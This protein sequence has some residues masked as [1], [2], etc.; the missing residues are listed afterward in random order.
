MKSIL[1][2]LLLL[3]S[4][5]L[6]AQD[7]IGF[8]IVANISPNGNGSGGAATG[9]L[10]SPW[11]NSDRAKNAEARR[12][13]SEKRYDDNM[14]VIVNKA[15]EYQNNAKKISDA[16]AEP[17]R[18]KEIL[19][20]PRLKKCYDACINAVN[21]LNQYADKV[22][23]LAVPGER[24]KEIYDQT[25]VELQHCDASYSK[26]GSL[27]YIANN[28]EQ[29]YDSKNTLFE[30][31]KVE[32]ANRDKIY[33]QNLAIQEKLL[34][35]ALLNQASTLP[36][37]VIGAGGII[38]KTIADYAADVYLTD[39]PAAKPIYV[40]TQK[41]WESFVDKHIIE[42]EPITADML[43]KINNQAMFRAGMA[44]N[45][46]T[47]EFE[48]HYSSAESAEKMI[49]FFSNQ[50]IVIK[51]QNQVVE[52]LRNSI[53][54]TKKLKRLN[55]ERGETTINGIN[56]YL[57]STDTPPKIAKFAAVLLPS[58]S[59]IQNYDPRL[60]VQNIQGSRL[61][62]F[63]TKSDY[64][65]VKEFANIAYNS[66]SR[67]LESLKSADCTLYP[68]FK[69]F[70]D[71]AVNDFT[72]ITL[73]NNKIQQDQ[74]DRYEGNPSYPVLAES[75]FVANYLI[76]KWHF[77]TGNQNLIRLRQ[78]QDLFTDTGAVSDKIYKMV[79]MRDEF[80]LK[81]KNQTIK[82]TNSITSK[83]N[84]RYNA[85]Q[86]TMSLINTYLTYSGNDLTTIPFSKIAIPSAIIINQDDDLT[87][88]YVVNYLKEKI[89][90]EK[91]NTS[92]LWL[93]LFLHLEKMY[94]DKLHKINTPNTDKKTLDHIKTPE[95]GR[96]INIDSYVRNFELVRQNHQEILE[97]M[98][99]G[100]YKF[101]EGL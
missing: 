73:L 24:K 13:A 97:L 75:N 9:Q 8:T 57:Q 88:A 47:D 36:N 3:I 51:L 95:S 58:N 50:N 10:E 11:S 96:L 82:Y 15:Q 6:K 67:S 28:T 37:M 83:K 33:S 55:L 7:P 32:I 89:L 98:E 59:E 61:P 63:A 31:T 56:L 41:F 34:N 4:A 80:Y 53:E 76:L 92:E 64:S 99:K 86:L 54:H 42:G 101:L 93:N 22:K 65:Q 84:N 27:T 43:D 19:D 68:I 44:L 85:E 21:V 81:L 70:H 20:C 26:I 35:Q 74:S 60:E 90:K 39:L 71:L 49:Q 79:K 87:E 78:C 5:F 77:Q 66:S 52:D 16:L 25:I 45:P 2:I 62:V 46:V 100:K 72:A 18:M 12:A 94:I 23:K 40:Y 29:L 1:V 48:D 91:T 14:S 38:T 69:N 17:K 30:L